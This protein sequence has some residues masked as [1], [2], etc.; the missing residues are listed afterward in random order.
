[1]YGW[2]DTVWI[3]AADNT[4]FISF[5]WGYDP[6]VYP[7][8]VEEMGPNRFLAFAGNAYAPISGETALSSV[9]AAFTGSIEHCEAGSPMPA[10]YSCK[11]SARASL[12][13][14]RQSRCES[15]QHRVTLT[16]R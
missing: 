2:Y 7:E 10:T 4:L 1:M 13:V 16:R 9:S 12:T 6:D 3:G 8:V 14:V 15:T 5:A 11:S